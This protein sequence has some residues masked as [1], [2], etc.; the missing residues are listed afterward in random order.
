MRMLKKLIDRVRTMAGIRK[1][2]Q[3][4]P[5]KGKPPLGTSVVRDNLR[6]RLSHPIDDEFWQWLSSMGW[7]SMLVN[8]HKNQRRYRVVSDK[9][10]VK[11][12]LADPTNRM[13]I[14][15][16]LTQESAR[17]ET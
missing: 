11:M 8:V 14:H 15:E 16:K 17:I 10:L 3:L 7:R 1:E 9:V 12:I 4:P 13:V 5:L 2:R 6:M